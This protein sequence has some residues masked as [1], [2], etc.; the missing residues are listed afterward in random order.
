P[1]LIS[2]DDVTTMF[3]EFGHALYAMFS[4]NY[5]P[6]QDGFNLPTDVIEF[7]SQFNEHWALDP[8]VLAHYAK[9]Y[10]TGAPI[11]QALVDKIKKASK[12]NQGSALGEVIAAAML[13]MDWPSLPA[14]A[15]KQDVDQFEAAALAK[16]GLDIA[17]VPPRY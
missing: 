15:G 9:D 4:V 1:A 12:F 11:P 5:Y 13:G 16:T 17:D 6:S 8:K 14:S 3:H 7:P 10:K 2:F